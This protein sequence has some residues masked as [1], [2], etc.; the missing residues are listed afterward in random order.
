MCTRIRSTVQGGENWIDIVAS[1]HEE[2]TNSNDA[3]GRL[4]EAAV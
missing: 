1:R 3:D 2:E 4:G